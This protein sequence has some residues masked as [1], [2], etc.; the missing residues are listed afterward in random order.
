VADG[1]PER[2]VFPE[3]R[4]TQIGHRLVQSLGKVLDDEVDGYLPVTAGGRTDL[5]RMLEA[6]ARDDFCRTRGLP[7]EHALTFG[8]LTDGNRERRGKGAGSDLDPL[9]RDQPLGLA[10]RSGRACRIPA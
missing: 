6:T 1:L 4:D 7:V 2:A 5:E 9:L 3:Q 8:R 10:D